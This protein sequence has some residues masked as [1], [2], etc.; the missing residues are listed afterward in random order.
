M[1]A[2]EMPEPEGNAARCATIPEAAPVGT[3]TPRA[4]ISGTEIDLN[5]C[6]V[7]DCTEAR[8]NAAT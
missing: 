3:W 6:I 7:V 4:A 1:P 8:W 5:N 2:P